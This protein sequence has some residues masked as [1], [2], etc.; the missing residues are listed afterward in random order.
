MNLRRFKKNKIKRSN[1]F[2][3]PDEVFLDSKNLAKLDTQQFE[4]RMEKPISKTSIL[5]VGLFFSFF[6][7]IFL[8]RLGILQIKKGQAYFERSENNTLTEVILFADRG[9]IYDRNGVELAW[10]KKES[11]TL[12]ALELPKE[13]VLEKEDV[14][15]GTRAYLSP[16]FS[17]VLGYVNSPTKDSSGNY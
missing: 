17:H 1:F 5:V 14:E 12:E 7:L 10:T 13:E 4:G 6:I 3:E 15:F 8:G 16:G 9:I 2:V 11:P